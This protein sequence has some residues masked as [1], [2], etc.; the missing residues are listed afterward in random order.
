MT[1]GAFKLYTEAVVKREKQNIATQ[2]NIIR[3]AHHAAAK[4]FKG[5]VDELSDS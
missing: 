4:Q 5:F 2:S 3:M 1:Y